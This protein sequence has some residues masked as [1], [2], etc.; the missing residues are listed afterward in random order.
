MEPQ[1]QIERE[2]AELAEKF[3]RSLCIPRDS[4]RYGG[5]CEGYEQ[6]EGMK[7]GDS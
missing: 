1:E 2:G 7:R 3:Y 5:I 4:Y 6:R